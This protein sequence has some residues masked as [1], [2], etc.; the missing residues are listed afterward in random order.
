M[1]DSTSSVLIR[2][3]VSAIKSAF[4]EVI[5]LDTRPSATDDYGIPELFEDAFEDDREKEKIPSLQDISQ[6]EL[7]VS[8]GK[9]VRCTCHVVHTDSEIYGG[10]FRDRGRW[11]LGRYGL[12]ATTNMPASDADLVFEERTSLRCRHIHVPATGG[13][14]QSFE[15]LSLNRGGSEGTQTQDFSVKLYNEKEEG[16]LHSCLVIIGIL[17]VV[18]ADVTLHSIITQNQRLSTVIT[19]SLPSP[20]PAD[21]PEVRAD[22]LH[23]LE[24]ALEGDAL[25][26]ELCLLSLISGVSVRSPMLIGPLTLNI[27]GLSPDTAKAL[28]SL[29][30]DLTCTYSFDMSIDNLNRS[31]LYPSHDG[32]EFS[33]GTL[34]L[35]A[36][37]AVILNESA[38]SEGKLDERG[39]KNLQ[40]LS[41][42]IT[43][44]DLKFQFPFSE[45]KIPVD[46]S[47]ITLSHGK[48]LLPS[49]IS[50]P[51]TRS[52]TWNLNAKS[53]ISQM[54]HYL[55]RCRLFE[56][57]IQE[58][59]SKEVQEDFV[60]SRKEGHPMDQADLS[61]AL[62]LGKEIAKSYS[63]RQMTWDDYTKAKSLRKRILS[64]E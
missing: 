43:S 46:L 61:M 52:S 30:S 38:L 27:R 25:A 14:E 49:T 18:G 17:E 55:A 10:A 24:G 22:L 9:L 16:L 2:D 57:E 35:P 1:V 39:V 64:R 59:V 47:F 13:F 58:E 56:I 5:G 37:F 36:D 40:C 33:A 23:R 60:N 41:N 29:V 26:A 20:T 53:S 12:D 19:S 32:E 42:T 11:Q 31:K 15:N 8:N 7:P 48:S 50:V 34:Q 54:R 44:Q 63:R 3:S 21:I 4:E 28:T 51:L 6:S 62:A 45:F